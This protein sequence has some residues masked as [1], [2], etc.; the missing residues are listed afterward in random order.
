MTLKKNLLLK[1]GHNISKFDKHTSK[2]TEALN[3]T[4]RIAINE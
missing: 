2:L 4:D 3:S 1:M